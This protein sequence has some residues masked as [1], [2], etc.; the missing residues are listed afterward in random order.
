MTCIAYDTTVAHLDR[1]GFTDDHLEVHAGISEDID[2]AVGAREVDTLRKYFPDRKCTSAVLTFAVV[3]RVCTWSLK[4]SEG[5]FLATAHRDLTSR[6]CLDRSLELFRDFEVF[7]CVIL[8]R[9]DH[10]FELFLGNIR[11]VVVLED[12]DPTMEELESDPEVGES[13]IG[14][15]HKDDEGVF[16]EIEEHTC[17]RI[18]FFACENLAYSLRR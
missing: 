11:E 8:K 12:V 15:L 2:F 4:G 3:T 9:I 1:E 18:L 13:E 16:G 7:W 6:S 5:E 10:G 14:R 17:D